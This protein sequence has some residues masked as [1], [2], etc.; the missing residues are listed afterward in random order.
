MTVP[1]LNSTGNIEGNGSSG[2]RIFSNGVQ[3]YLN[4]QYSHK[5]K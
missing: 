1:C 5:E 3:N 2:E 4:A